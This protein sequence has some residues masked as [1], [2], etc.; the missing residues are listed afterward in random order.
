MRDCCCWYTIIWLGP[1][2]SYKEIQIENTREEIAE[3]TD[4]IEFWISIGVRKISRVFFSHTKIIHYYVLLFYSVFV[5]FVFTRMH[6]NWQKASTFIYYRIFDRK[7]LDIFWYLLV[8]VLLE[9][10]IFRRF[11]YNAVVQSKPNA[12]VHAINLKISVPSCI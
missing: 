1:E 8:I 3:N 9:L 5:L 6:N 11:I 10:F 4:L 12:S 2:H 7:F